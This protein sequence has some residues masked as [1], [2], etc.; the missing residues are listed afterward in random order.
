MVQ[1]T[2]EME[3]T[4]CKYLAERGTITGR[5]DLAGQGTSSLVTPTTKVN[6]LEMCQKLGQSRKWREPKLVD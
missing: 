1:I 2:P 6:K 4:Y 3:S 5:Q